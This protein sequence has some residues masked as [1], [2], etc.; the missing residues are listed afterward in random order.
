MY[1][2]CLFVSIYVFI[3]LS[4]YLCVYLP[5]YISICL[6]ICPQSIH[7]S[8][9]GISSIKEI[10]IE[11]ICTSPKLRRRKKKVLQN[12]QMPVLLSTNTDTQHLP[13]EYLICVRY[14]LDLKKNRKSFPDLQKHASTL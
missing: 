10:V 11:F 12:I 9:L 7:L 1:L 3:F 6:S 5:M 14:I 8:C 4:I 13:V 2:L